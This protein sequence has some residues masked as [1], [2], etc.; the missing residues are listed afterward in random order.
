MNYRTEKDSLGEIKVPQNAYWGAQTQRAVENFPISGLRFPRAFIRALGLMKLCAARVN[1][2]LKLL[3]ER[4]A[5][6]IE[7]AAREVTDGKLDEH[8]PIDIFQTGSGTSTNMNANEVIANR[9]CEILGVKRGD[10]TAV[11]PNDHVNLGQSSND[12]IPACVHISAALS[13]H[14]QLLPAL[15]HLQKALE[16]KAREFS[17]MVKTGRTHLMDAMPITL[18]QQFSG[19]TAQMTLACERLEAAKPRL[20]ELALGGTAVG[21]GI[22]TH[23]EF[24]WRIAQALAQETK[25]AFTETRNHFAAQATMET[26][27]ELSGALKALA[28]ALYKIANDLRWMNSGPQAGLAEIRL[29]E[30]Q[31]GSSIMPGKVNPVIP[32]AVMMVSMQ[33]MGNDVVVTQAAASGNFELNVAL[34]VIAHNLLQTISILSNACR[35]FADKCITGIVANREQM[36]RL[37]NQNAILATALNPYIGYDKAAE[38]VKRALAQRKTIREIVLE[39]KLLPP[40][41]LDEILDIRVMTQ[42]GFIAGVSGGG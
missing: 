18:G 37:A 29:P 22:N 36:E 41:K 35:V 14:E 11:H 30:L 33:V 17:D 7:Q 8:F 3:D 5:K 39:M 38:V 34:P 40:E 20:Y 19:Y 24:G 12:V 25:I 13:V 1:L 32:E 15:E 9:A 16:T 31:P 26:A 27:V 23:S 2:Q 28:V 42:G 6:V 21:T 4:H 10:K